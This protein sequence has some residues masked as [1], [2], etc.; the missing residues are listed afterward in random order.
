MFP[1][2]RKGGAI[3][4][5]YCSTGGPAAAEFFRAMQVTPVG[6]PE[7]RATRYRLGGRFRPGRICAWYDRPMLPE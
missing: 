4:C 1:L 3:L 6:D 7:K 5:A 2:F